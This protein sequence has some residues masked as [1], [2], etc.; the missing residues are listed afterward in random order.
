MATKPFTPFLYLRKGRSK[1]GDD[2]AIWYIVKPKPDGEGGWK[3]KFTPT[4]CRGAA[5]EAEAKKILSGVIRA[6]HAGK[7]L[8][9]DAET[10][11]MTVARWAP[12]WLA[13]RT[14]KGVDITPYE[15]YLRV[16][17]LPV[18]GHLR[19]DAVTGDHIEEVMTAVAAKGLAPKT[20]INAYF[21]MRGMF[22]KAVGKGLLE[23]NPC[24]MDEDDLP[25]KVDADPEWR[26]TAIFD[27]DEVRQILTSSL[28]PLDRQAYYA[29]SF[30]AGPRFGEVSALLVRHCHLDV[31]PLGRLDV[32]RSYNS[33]RKRLKATK[34]NKPRK[35]P[36]HP[37]LEPILRAW[38]AYG[39]A[40][41]MGREPRPDDPLIPARWWQ[42]RVC[43]AGGA[44]ETFRHRPYG[45]MYKRYQK[46]LERL[47]LRGRRQHDDRR[48]FITLARADGAGKDLLRLVTHGPEGDIMDIYSETDVLW[49]A[50]C[51]EVAKLRMDLPVPP[52]PL[53]LVAKPAELLD[54][55]LPSGSHAEILPQIPLV[56]SW[57][58]QGSN[59][60]TPPLQGPSSDSSDAQ[61]AESRDLPVAP[62]G[63]GGTTSEPGQPMATLATLALRQAL[64]ALDRGRI[65]EVRAI[66][67]RALEAE[68]GQGRGAASRRS[69]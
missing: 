35:V 64:D 5:G 47:G 48:T 12:L 60:V 23:D 66:L 1:A 7:V 43:P 37:S 69:R 45:T 24:K 25:A 4:K 32:V 63:A 19:L 33:K 14:A 6:L 36:V 59:T 21:T 51:A 9:G 42:G 15:S 2:G 65:D 38:L 13:T 67:E 20:R 57:A 58:Q 68:R 54:G 17:I 56:T 46:D 29:V 28:V 10:G 22:R 39:F 55:G 27:R 11:P 8:G 50:L 61:T 40:A 16:H 44:P 52:E 62:P 31:Q 30:L 53:V 3:K 49:P 18:I 34:S 26:S 41:Y